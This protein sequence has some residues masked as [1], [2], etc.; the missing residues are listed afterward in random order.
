M[1]WLERLRFYLAAVRWGVV[2]F[3]SGV[4]DRRGQ[5]SAMGSDDFVHRS[6]AALELLSRFAPEAYELVQQYIKA[7]VEWRGG[8]WEDLFLSSQGRYWALV[9]LDVQNRDVK[10]LAS[11][12]AGAAFHVSTL[13]SKEP[14]VSLSERDMEDATTEFL[15]VGRGK[16]GIEGSLPKGLSK[17]P[18]K[19]VH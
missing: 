10:E 6:M 16:L 19:W 8:G 18:G 5:V 7:V 3:V 9:G 12:L 14:N 11:F 13:H 15:L 4:E 2:W 17:T 1:G